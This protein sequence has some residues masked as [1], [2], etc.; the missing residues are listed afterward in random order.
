MAGPA[1]EVAGAPPAPEPGVTRRAEAVTVRPARRRPPARLLWAAAFTAAAIALFAAYI[2]LS[3]TYPVNSDGANIV[4]MSWDMLHGNLLLH[5]WWMSDVSFYT[6]ELP[7][8]MLIDAIRGLSP[9]VTHIAAALT[10]TLVLV[11]TVLLAKSRATSRDGAARVLIAGGIMLAPQLGVGIFVLLLS[12][13]HIGT[14]VPVLAVWLL[15]DRAPR[16]WYIPVSAAII[17]GWA[18]V[19]D[20]L[21]LVVAIVPL[22]LVSVARAIWWPAAGTT[23]AGT[24][25]TGGEEAHRRNARHAGTAG[26]LP[27]LRSAWYERLR[28]GWYELSLA[29]AAITAAGISWLLQRAIHAAGGYTVH[30]IPF[31]LVT[32]AR[33][34]VHAATTGDSLLALFGAN[35]GGLHSGA[36]VAFAVLHLAGLALVAWALGRT[37][38]RFASCGLIDQVL[39]VAIV[40]N[41][42]TYLFSSFSSGVLNGRE[43]A[44]VLPFGAALAARSLVPELLA[45]LQPRAARAARV[46]AWLPARVPA[47][48][49]LTVLAGTMLTGNG[50]CLGYELAQP[51]SPPANARLASWLQAH[52][53]THGLSGYWQAS[54]VT[55]GTGGRV[56]IR[57]VSTADGGLVPYRWEAKAPW[58]DPGTQYANFVLLQ[59]QAGFFNDWRPARE[60]LATFGPPEQTFHTGPY[61][62]LVYQQ[63]LMNALHAWAVRA[64]AAGTAVTS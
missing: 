29:G 24:A 12:V 64:G 10:Y 1:Q 49:L 33:L 8:Y 26:H 50:A 57:A 45:A 16:R 30:Q 20:S 38:R 18:M 9:D 56:T 59:N 47:R 17:L 46:S 13:G 37:L 52:H 39:A 31:G 5:T 63:N 11:L 28:S 34:G 62:V 14:A 43:I 54:V 61:T 60:T 40:V 23:V 15:L 44:L 53:L 4:L 41:L 19:A 48:L 21:I 55:V 25:A 2:R 36:A 42:A 58:Y 22:A 7:E 6:T 51:V 3:A 32:P 35:F 27:R